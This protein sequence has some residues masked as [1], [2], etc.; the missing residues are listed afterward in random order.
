MIRPPHRALVRSLRHRPL[1][2]A[3]VLAAAAVVAPPHHSSSYCDRRRSPHHRRNAAE[4][5]PVVSG[6]PGDVPRRRRITQRLD[7]LVPAAQRRSASALSDAP[8]RGIPGGLLIHTERQLP[9][10]TVRA[11]RELLVLRHDR[12]GLCASA[13]QNAPQTIDG[14][15][16]GLRSHACGDWLR[17]MV[18]GGSTQNGIP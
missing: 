11:R 5:W 17:T 13:V 14:R 8:S 10:H 15:R 7:R 6:I 16:H 12:A 3:I 2:H 1:R 4:L 9:L 18:S